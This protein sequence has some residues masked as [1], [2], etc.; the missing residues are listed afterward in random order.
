M[1]PWPD[2]LPSSALRDKVSVETDPSQK[3]MLSAC[4]QPLE[5]VSFDSRGFLSDTPCNEQGFTMNH[6]TVGMDT[7]AGGTIPSASRIPWI[8]PGALVVARAISAGQF[9]VPASTTIW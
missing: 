6:S 7:S 1:S 3:R 8:S 9:F 5:I 2:R 4:K